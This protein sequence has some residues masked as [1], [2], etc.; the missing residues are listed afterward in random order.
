M[1]KLVIALALIITLSVPASITSA[2]GRN[3]H[4]RHHHYF[5]QRHHVEQVVSAPVN[6]GSFAYYHD[7][8]GKSKAWYLINI[9]KLP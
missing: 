4:S 3:Y 8:L 6:D 2:C 7:V 5:W 1:K 9:H